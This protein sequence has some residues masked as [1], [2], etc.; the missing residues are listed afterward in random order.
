MTGRTHDLAAFTALNILFVWAPLTQIS[1][2]TLVVAIGANFIGGLAPDLDRS[3]ASLWKKVRGGS[4]LGPLLAPLLGGHRL[5]SHSLVGLV[6]TGILLMK[7]LTL[8]NQIL[9]V[10]MQIVWLAFMIGMVSHLIA[11]ALTK[12]GIPLL[13]PFPWEFGIP[14][15]K[16]IRI[17]TGKI[18]EKSFIYP[19]LMLV[20]GYCF[21][22]YV[23]KYLNFFRNFIV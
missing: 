23:D 20:N 16:S 12:D 22:T 1:L 14:P 6:L 15:I 2:G 5:I 18:V 13:F 4:I 11:D 10:D 8:V 17:T 7:F 21:Y 3:T 19:G 9:L